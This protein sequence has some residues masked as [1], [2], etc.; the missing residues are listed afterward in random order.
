MLALAIAGVS[1][2]S[3]TPPQD[4][5]AKTRAAIL[6]ASI[7]LKIAGYLSVDAPPSAK[8]P[9]KY[10]IAVVGTDEVAAA[11]TAHLPG[12]KVGT[13]PV[14]VVEL[15][16]ADAAEGK[17]LG[18][19]D[20]IYVAASVDEEQAKK[21]VAAHSRAPVPLVCE[22]AGLAAAGGTVQLFVQD[23]G[24]RFEVNLD[25]LKKQGVRADPQLLKL[26]KKGPS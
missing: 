25:A 22:R 20:L 12:K 3:A 23:N 10:R 4:H 13:T 5:E 19:Y 21:I 9:E 7:V 15:R 16:P 11:I 24:V 1:Q 6:R 26:S 17:G 18:S 8:P 2:S 14:V